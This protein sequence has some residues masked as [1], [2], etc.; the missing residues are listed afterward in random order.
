MTLRV[1]VVVLTM[2]DRP[3]QEAL[4]QKTLLAQTGI[5]VRVCVV[6]NGCTPQVVPSGALTVALPENIG[7]PG[8]RNAGADALRAA[9]DPAD[10]V[11]FLDND[12]C[13]PRPDVLVRLVA[14]A[15]EHPE[16]AYV[17][18][19]LTG[20]D[21]ATAPRRWVPRLRVGDPGR[22]GTITTMT[23][24]VVLVRRR[25]FD[26]VGGW[27]SSLFLYHEGLDLAYR[28]WSAG[29]TGWYAA[30]IRMHHPV[31]SPARHRQFHRLAARNR[32]SVA[33]RN[34]PAP[35]IPLYLTAW[36]V[37]TL[38]RAARGGG[39]RESLRGMYEGWTTRHA[40]T[41]RPMGWRTVARLTAAGRPPV[42]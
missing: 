24:G 8:G 23:E 22:P 21:D 39:L 38:A 14:A 34:L 28:C 10:Y 41:R 20:P 18:P 37:I 15:E 4:A 5:K 19:R 2:G 32:I 25:V 31:T 3:E 17:Q 11:F 13:L 7:I 27:E 1:D 16:A 42:I 40:Q 6:G 9:G 35:L 30:D 33:Y 26:E 29:Y 12:A 36:T